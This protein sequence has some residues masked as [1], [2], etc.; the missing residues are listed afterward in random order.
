MGSLFPAGGGCFPIAGFG[1]AFLPGVVGTAAAEMWLWGFPVFV[2]LFGLLL[3]C[4]V[5]AKRLEEEEARKHAP[6]WNGGGR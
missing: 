4:G 3:Y 1:C 5:R 6:P 2:G